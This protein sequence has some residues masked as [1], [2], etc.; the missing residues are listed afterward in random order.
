MGERIYSLAYADDS[1]IDGRKGRGIEKHDGKI[2]RV[3]REEEV[4]IKSE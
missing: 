4:G 3:F 2:R 1:S